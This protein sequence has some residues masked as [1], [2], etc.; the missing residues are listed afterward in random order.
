VQRN[1]KTFVRDYYSTVN[2]DSIWLNQPFDENKGIRCRQD[3]TDKNTYFTLLPDPEATYRTEQVNTAIDL[4]LDGTT[5]G[6]PVATIDMLS[7]SDNNDKY[8]LT[9]RSGRNYLQGSTDEY[10]NLVFTGGSIGTI[11]F[12]GITGPQPQQLKQ[13]TKCPRPVEEAADDLPEYSE[14]VKNPLAT[15]SEKEL[16]PNWI[17]VIMLAISMVSAADGIMLTGIVERLQ[18]VPDNRAHACGP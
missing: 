14:L 8:Q 1:D 2:C 6:R 17:G 3:R 10:A 11:K 5:T 16:V 15:Y 18:E 4:D 12:T 7:Q 13:Q 9:Q